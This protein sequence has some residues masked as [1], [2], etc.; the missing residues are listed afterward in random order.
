MSRLNIKKIETVSRLWKNEII[1]AWIY[2]QKGYWVIGEDKMQR[3]LCQAPVII[4]ACANSLRDCAFSPLSYNAGDENYS[5]VQELVIAGEIK[6]LVW[7]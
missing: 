7:I 3:F 4:M 1:V 5:D 6:K 2:L